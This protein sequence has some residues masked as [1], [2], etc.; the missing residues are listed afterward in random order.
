LNNVH[1]SRIP[2]LDFLA[3]YFRLLLVVGIA[4]NS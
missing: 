4:K 2:W 1:G 3:A